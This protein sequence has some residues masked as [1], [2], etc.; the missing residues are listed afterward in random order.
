MRK[1]LIA[2]AIATS[3]LALARPLHA[4]D[5]PTQKTAPAVS[6]LPP[7]TKVGRALTKALSL[8]TGDDAAITEA[9]LSESFLK[10]VPLKQL[11]QV[12]AQIHA[13]H[14]E[15]LL[16][17]IDEGA[18]EHALVANVTGAK[19]KT[20]FKVRLSLDD[21]DKIVAFLIQPGVD[22]RA[23][24]L[25]SWDDLKVR[26]NAA[27]EKTSFTLFEITER[28]TQQPGADGLPR[29]AVVY[30]LQGRVRHHSEDPLA[31]GSTFKL[32]VLGA[33]AQA[34][35]SGDASWDQKYKVQTAL[36]SLPSGTMQDQPDGK[37]FT[38]REFAEKMISISDNTATDHLI[39]RLGRDRCERCMSRCCPVHQDLNKPFLKT[40]D[41]FALKLSGS[42]HLPNK[43]I[44]AGEMTRRELISAGGDVGK[45]QP[46][47][48]LAAAWKAPRFI[49]SLE[50]FASG[51]DLCSTMY[52]LNDLAHTKGLEPVREILAINPGIP[53]DRNVWAYAGYKGGSEPGVLSL[54]W[55]LERKD[56]RTFVLSITFND[57]RKAVDEGLGIALAQRAVEF[58]ATFDVKADK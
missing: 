19:S 26:L 8:F 40:R 4:Q 31:I 28:T 56:G 42:D 20:A 3:L 37:E 10:A 16:D 50:W 12:A 2:L 35:E 44:H 57:T 21:Q 6:V 49:D 34:I 33:L 1:V 27:A 24:A 32:W 25:K 43:F 36:K 30:D 29:S 5:A 22:K 54:T 38:L 52:F 53:L 45:Q 48:M 15:L 39:E 17:T 14:G 11:Q 23:P 9:D 58:L 41:L 47:A 13:A 55:L 18:S 46:H 51:E 7:D